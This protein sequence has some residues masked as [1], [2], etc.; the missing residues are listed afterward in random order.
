MEEDL[1]QLRGIIRQRSLRIGEFI[2]SSGKKSSYYLD[3]RMT[4]LDP[5]GALLIGR[6]ILDRIRRQK[7]AADAIG[8]LTI[9]ADP[10]ATAVA[11]VSAIEGQPL[12]AFIVR[13]E[14]KGH[15]TQRS[16]EGYDG[17]RGSRVIVVDDVCTTGESILKA[18]EQA[19][20]AGYEVVAAFC[21]V[22]REEG[23]TELIAKRY[24]F[25]SLFTAKELLNDA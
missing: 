18:A 22:D 10:I 14:T 15:G 8:G 12:S 11:V 23:G 17:K 9:G 4:T 19:E 16:I 25:Y 7:I 24:P 2:L 1:R 20:E 3:C 5:K 21:V 6:L 13:K